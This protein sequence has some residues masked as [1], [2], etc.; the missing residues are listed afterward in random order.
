MLTYLIAFKHLFKTKLS[1]KK[2]LIFSYFKDTANYLYEQLKKDSV[3]LSA[4]TVNDKTPV[5][6]ILTGDTPGKQREEKVKRFSPKANAENEQELTTLQENQI[7]ILICTDVLSEGQNLQ[8]AGVLIN[9]DL[10]WNPVRMIQRAGRIDRLGTDYDELFIYNCFP[11]QGLEDLLGLVKRL[12]K[13][14]ADI[15]NEVGLDGSVLGEAI[16]EKSLEELYRLKMAQTDAD[17]QAI[18]EELELVSDLVSLDEMRLPLLEFLQQASKEF[19]EDIPF[20]IHSTLIKNITYPDINEGGIFLDF[21]VGDQHLWHFYPR[22]Q[23]VICLDKSKL[24]NDRHTIFKWLK[25]EASDFL[26]PDDLPSIP[27]DKEI[28]SVLPK[29]VNNL[30]TFFQK[31]QTDQIIKP[32]MTKFLQIIHHTITNPESNPDFIQGEIIEEEVK[33]RVLKVIT[34]VPY[35]IYEKDVKKIWA[36]FNTHKDISLLISD[37]DEY[38][39][40]NDQYEK[41]EDVQDIRPLEIIEE[42]DIKLICYQWFKPNY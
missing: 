42:K 17:K 27:F 9:Y 26:N 25:C 18:L 3:W 6:E 7:D 21:R 23:G 15:D 12:Q 1:G 28:F 19:I 24:I 16:S 37:L 30:L 40:D 36:K 33:T 29:A 38:F 8:D 14:I 5:I 13:R 41:H 2:V 32:K 39:V 34:T 22:I 35:R 31:Q 10:H 4:I 11:E 20:G